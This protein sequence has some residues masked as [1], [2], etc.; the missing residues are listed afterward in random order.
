MRRPR[1]PHGSRDTPAVRLP[2]GCGLTLGSLQAAAEGQHGHQPEH[3]VRDGAPR[4]GALR[5]DGGGPPAAPRRCWCSAPP[6]SSWALLRSSRT[7]FRRPVWTSTSGTPTTRWRWT[8]STSSPAPTPAGTSSSSSEVLLC[9]LDPSGPSRR[10][11]RS[12]LTQLP[13]FLLP[14]QMLPASC[15]SEP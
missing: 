4:G 15:R 6:S 7:S 12:D 1:P 10:H 9:I 3:Q 2:S 8:S 14:P 5:E 11:G 13:H